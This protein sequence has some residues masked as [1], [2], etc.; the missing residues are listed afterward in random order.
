MS[1]SQWGHDVPMRRNR[2]VR[3][4][5]GWYD[6]FGEVRISPAAVTVS[7]GAHVL[8][9]GAFVDASG[10]TLSDMAE[11]NFRPVFYLAPPNRPLTGMGSG[12]R[13][14]YV[15]MGSGGTGAGPGAAAGTQ[16]GTAP[17]TLPAPDER[18]DQTGPP[19]P[20]QSDEAVFTIIEVDQEAV[21]MANSAAPAY[22]PLMLSEGVEGTVIVRYVVEINGLADS[23]SLEIVSATRREFADAVRAAIPYMRFTPA[24]IDERPV[25]QLVE[26]PFSF[27]IRRP[28]TED[29]TASPATSRLP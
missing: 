24:R 4:I 3:V 11:P 21:R 29:T 16:E 23:S 8:L 9:L 18:G 26:Q 25:K 6:S 22:P 19:T 1:I 20:A 12:E 14:A 28:E 5:G 15:A 10:P 2:A 13:I 27:R 7:V 17:S